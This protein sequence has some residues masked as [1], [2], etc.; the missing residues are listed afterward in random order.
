[1][2]VAAEG[3]WNSLTTL[4]K[5]ALG[6]GIPASA[7]VLYI[8]YR[9]YRE[10]R[11]SRLTFLGEDEIEVEMKVPRQVVKSI[12][13]RQ[14][15]IIK[16]LR[17]ET[18]ACIDIEAQESEG[19]ESEPDRVLLIRGAPVQVCRAKMAIHQIL[20]DSVQ[21]LEHFHV[22]QQSVGRII[23][24]GGEVI[25]AICR[26][27]GAKVACEK[28]TG[29]HRLALERLITLTGTK[30]EVEV[31]KKLILEKVEQE[32][33]FRQ[34]IIQS[35]ASRRQMKKPLGVR[36]EDIVSE[37]EENLCVE[38][39]DVAAETPCEQKTVT[40]S[41]QD[42]LKFEIPSPDLSF[43]PDEH[44]EVYVSASEN[45]NHFWIQ[46]LGARSLQLD[47]LITEMSRYYE[48]SSQSDKLASVQVGDIVA[49]P[50]A[51]DSSWYRARVL[52]FLEDGLVDLYYVDFGDNGV[53]P[54]EKLGCLRSDFLSLPFQAV[55][56][57][58]A[59]IEP[60]GEA[61]S[62][63]ALDDFDRL[64]Y[65]TQW[66]PLMARI[67]S[68]SQ[69]GV[70]TWPHVQLYDANN[71]K[72]LSIGEELVRL[73]HAVQCP[74]SPADTNTGVGDGADASWPEKDDMTDSLRKLLEEVTGMSQSSLTSEVTRR[75]PED[76]LTLSC[77]SLSE[78]ASVSGSGDE[79]FLVEEDL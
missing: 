60:A 4:Q 38:S 23:G 41:P 50:F 10:T 63:D 2:S 27:S 37:G 57:S 79:V 56:C 33:E 59:E 1:M 61:W 14:G 20:T 76:Q 12:I 43:Q 55:E 45:P 36:K 35:A 51:H 74:Q 70:S 48:A 15:A 9:R 66:K 3:S 62:E 75:T 53:A 16:Q 58:L 46:I 31:A 40:E 68:Y 6:L 11:D 67:C 72:Y 69:T 78:G 8:L 19:E 5:V 64:T 65:C 13:G 39:I 17:R 22:P 34:K 73:G 54:L 28:E 25:R 21:I 71:E 18:G 32:R 24:R 26:E 7:T 77:L 44:L 42:V 30:K 49:A 47:K 52:G 29:D